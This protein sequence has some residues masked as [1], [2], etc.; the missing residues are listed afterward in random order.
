MAKVTDRDKMEAWRKK[1]IAEIEALE[2]RASG[3]LEDAK[4]LRAGAVAALYKIATAVP[5]LSSA[6]SNGIED[7]HKQIMKAL[8]ALHGEADAL[9]M[10]DTE[11][12]PDTSEE[13]DRDEESSSA[14]DNLDIPDVD[15][16]MTQAVDSLDGTVDALSELLSG[17][18]GIR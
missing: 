4:K 11:D 9:E 15:D 8:I 17:L 6:L 12:Y 7:R 14:L 5:K 18:R 2:S 16:S 3:V 10:V 1:S 13:D